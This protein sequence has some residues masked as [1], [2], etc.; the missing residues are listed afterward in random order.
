[1]KKWRTRKILWIWSYHFKLRDWYQWLKNVNSTVG[2]VLQTFLKSKFSYFF[3]WSVFIYI[4]LRG[5]HR[6]WF[7]KKTVSESSK[8]T[9]NTTFYNDMCTFFQVNAQFQL[10]RAFNI[11]DL[12]NW[13]KKTKK[14]NKKWY[15]KLKLKKLKT[16]YRLFEKLNIFNIERIDWIYEKTGPPATTLLW[17]HAFWGGLLEFTDAVSEIKHI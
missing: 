13:T 14:K 11:L 4:P 7:W 8:V 1:M 9:Q 6:T 10:A 15:T 17:K 3:P 12:K 2:T 5:L 16:Y